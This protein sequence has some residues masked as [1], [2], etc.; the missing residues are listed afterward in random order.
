MIAVSALSKLIE[1]ICGM[2]DIGICIHDVSGILDCE[3]LEIKRENRVHSFPYC[4]ASKTTRSGYDACIECKTLSNERAAETGHPFS[5]YCTAGIFEVVYPVII[6]KNVYCIIYVGNI[7]L[8][9]S[10][11]EK[12]ALSRS[13]MTGTDMQKLLSL[14]DTLD[15]GRSCDFYARIAEAIANC[16][17]STALA[18]GCLELI[19]KRSASYAVRS[20]LEYIECNLDKKLTLKSIAALYYTNEKY[21]GKL[22]TREVGKSFNSYINSLRLKKACELLRTTKKSV[23]EVSLEVGFTNVTYFNRRFRE[24][25]DTTPTAARKNPK[26]LEKK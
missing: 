6:E 8:E 19:N 7:T 4:N 10:T 15:C 26:P 3:E 9:R 11:S 25:F 13:E 24:K 23:I 14:I 22:F 5:R 17:T 12:I 2:S 20:A 21:L 1:V 16:I 18:S